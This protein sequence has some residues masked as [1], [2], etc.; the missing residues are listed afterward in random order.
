MLPTLP[1]D[2]PAAPLNAVAA[3]WPAALARRQ[4][5]GTPVGILRVTP[6]EYIRLA[7]SA[8]AAA[9]FAPLD[10]SN[11]CPPTPPRKSYSALN[12]LPLPRQN[13]LLLL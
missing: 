2:K 6:K 9:L 11:R 4:A 12:A 7:P 3:A 13:T 1:F 8:A 5:V 10:A